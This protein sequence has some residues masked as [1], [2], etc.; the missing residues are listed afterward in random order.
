MFVYP[1][2]SPT[3]DGVATD[4]GTLVLLEGSDTTTVAVA[5]NPDAGKTVPFGISGWLSD[6]AN[7]TSTTRTSFAYNNSIPRVFDDGGTTKLEV[8]R[9]FADE[10]DEVTL[11][12]PLVTFGNDFGVQSIESTS[13]S[14]SATSWT[15]TITSVDTTKAFVLCFVKMA[16]GTTAGCDDALVRVELTDSTTL[17]FYRGGS[18][19][20]NVTVRCYVVEDVSAGNTRFSVAHY[21]HTTTSTNSNKTI[22]AVTDLAKTSLIVTG[23]TDTGFPQ[24]YWGGAM[25]QL[26]TTTNINVLKAST[27]S[28]TLGLQ[29]IE[30]KDGTEVQ[31]GSTTY[32]STAAD[33]EQTWTVALSPSVDTS[34]SIA[35][36]TCSYNPKLE[37]P[38]TTNNSW[39]SYAGKSRLTLDADGSGVTGT[40]QGTASS[41]SAHR[42]FWEV[43]T[44]GSV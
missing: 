42:A 7:T 8:S 24:M 18:P 15:A 41:S 38:C 10:A 43:I 23:Q 26:T 4:P 29:V 16:D 30:W 31:R 32:T 1:F 13:P 6:I 11:A 22:S 12:V 20:V 33:T 37:L 14:G 5:G 9:R 21:T 34:K 19:T 25:A 35:R 2:F 3:T 36:H 40:Y 44:F 17:T 28:V 27:V 39:Q